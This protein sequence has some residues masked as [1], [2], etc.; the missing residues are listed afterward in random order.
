MTKRTKY[1]LLQIFISQ[2]NGRKKKK[3]KKKMNLTNHTIT[4]KNTKLIREHT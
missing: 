4:V 2:Y 1:V 3:K